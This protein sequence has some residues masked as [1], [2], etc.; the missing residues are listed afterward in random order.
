MNLGAAAGMI[1]GRG[2]QPLAQPST[3]Q[4]S[5]ARRN[6]WQ[7]SALRGGGL[8]GAADRQ[9]YRF[10][11]GRCWIDGMVHSGDDKGR[12]SPLK[13]PFGL[14]SGCFFFLPSREGGRGAPPRPPSRWGKKRSFLPR[15][16]GKAAY[17][18]T[19]AES[20]SET[21]ADAPPFCLPSTPLEGCGACQCHPTNGLARRVRRGLSARDVTA[22]GR[23]R[24]NDTTPRP[25]CSALAPRECA[26]CRRC[27]GHA[28]PPPRQL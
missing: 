26:L 8:R 1:Q 2:R 21:H 12:G 20:N 17:W 15:R 24:I 18:I 25:P 13:G 11:A 3:R 4:R 28:V 23:P 19:A 10:T 14:C 9:R 7:E 27:P 6:R 5:Y 16:L 22:P